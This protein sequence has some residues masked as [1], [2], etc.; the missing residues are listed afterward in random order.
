MINSKEALEQIKFHLYAILEL[1]APELIR[2][3][4]KVFPIIEKDLKA[5]ELLKRYVKELARY[6]HKGEDEYWIFFD[7]M[8]GENGDLTK[9]EFELLKECVDT[10]TSD[11][12]Y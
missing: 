1:E 6:Q 5:C 2:H 8:E 11:T 9:D 7:G 12:V 4:D 10:R 3:Y